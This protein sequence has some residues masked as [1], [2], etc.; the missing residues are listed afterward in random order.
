M[1][2]KRIWGIAIVITTFTL[3]GVACSALDAILPSP[4]PAAETTP[5]REIAPPPLPPS[6]AT[7]T[8]VPLSTQLATEIPSC[9]LNDEVIAQMNKIEDQVVILRGLQS[10]RLV[11]RILLTQD[12]LGQQVIDDFLA[13][14]THEEAVNDTLVLALF[15]LL[16]P[17]FDLWNFYVDL[18]RE[19]VAGYYDDEVEQMAIICGTDFGGPERITYAHEY[20][21][22][23]QDQTYDLE[24]G[25]GYS[26]ELCEVDSE[27]CA[28]IQALV[29]G[30]ATLLQEQWM[31]TYA[32]EEDWA[33]LLEF[34]ASYES[35]VLESAPRFL[36]QDLLFPY[37]AG[38]GFVHNLYLDGGWATVDNAYLDPPLSTEQ[39]LHSERYPTDAPV[40]L[41]VP[42]LIT[43]LGDEWLEIDR[44]VLGEWYTRLMLTEH[45]PN[46][47][48]IEAAEG[49]GGDYYLVF[50]NNQTDQGAVVLVTQWDTMR[51]VHE[52]DAALRDYGDS[53]FGERKTSSTYEATWLGEAGYTLVE[54]LSNQ[55]LWIL[56]PDTEAGRALRQALPFPARQQ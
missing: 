34:A 5:T 50:Y 33:D 23:L 1:K 45:L 37:T 4:L 17:E 6:E 12:E 18:Y 7:D 55:T 36:H 21:H 49:W 16:E 32:T 52:F 35:P 8:A 29:E 22:S 44:N 30:D 9:D 15:G 13:D 3:V 46:E 42:D 10:V 20:T 19:Q 26:D 24:E 2:L 38:Y 40:W 14:Y 43:A 39:I 51:D 28:A 47:V 31:R 54:R 41:E 27:R 25:L 53:R 11:D 48:A 56:A